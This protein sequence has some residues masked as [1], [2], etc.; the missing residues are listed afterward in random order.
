MIEKSK[1]HLASN[2]FP[3]LLQKIGQNSS[4]PLTTHCS[5]SSKSFNPTEK[6]FFPFEF[7]FLFHFNFFFCLFNC[8]G[9]HPDEWPKR[10]YNVPTVLFPDNQN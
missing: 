7:Q 6:Y 10:G 9:A 8:R 3:L 2:P 5:G 4:K 1:T